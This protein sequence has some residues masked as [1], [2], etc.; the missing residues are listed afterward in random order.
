MAILWC[1]GILDQVDPIAAK[2]P[3]PP[4]VIC[5]KQGM[6]AC[7]LDCLYMQGEPMKKEL[8]VR[9]ECHTAVMNL[10][11]TTFWSREGSHSRAMTFLTS[12]SP[13]NHPLSTPSFIY[14][15]YTAVLLAAEHICEPLHNYLSWAHSPAINPSTHHYKLTIRCAGYKP[16]QLTWPQLARTL[17]CGGI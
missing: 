6:A 3:A 11:Q 9:S 5:G 17:P 12:G 1:C 7:A 10:Y 16:F 4:P 14:T 8:V 13:D 2:P 15:I